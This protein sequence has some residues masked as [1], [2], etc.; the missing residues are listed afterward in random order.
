[1]LGRDAV[2]SLLSKVLSLSEADQTEAV[3]LGRQSNLT[4]YANSV[5]HQNVAEAETT[6]RVRAV[7]GR[8]VGV[9]VTNDLREDSLRQVTEKAAT[10]A[11]LQA[12]NPDFRS[13]P[14]PD[15]AGYM[16]VDA[17]VESTAA[18]TPEERARTV[19]VVCRQAMD[20][21][22]SAAG[23]FSTGRQEI[24]VANSLGVFGYHRATS[25]ELIAL[26]MSDSGSGY[27]DRCGRDAGGIDAEAVA[28]EA[29]D[30]ALSSRNPVAVTPG[31]YE[32]VLQEYAVEDLV[33]SISQ[34][35]FSA[36]AVQEGRSFMRLGQKVVGDNVSVWDDALSP[37]GFPMP[38]DFEGVPKGRLH[39]I[40]NGLAKAVAYDSYTAGKEGRAST[41][42]ALPAPNAMGPLPVH[43]FLGTGES[44][45]EEMVRGVKRGLWV[46][47]FHYT[48]PV[49]PLKVIVTGMTRDGTFLIENGEIAR[50]VKNLRY[51][52]SYLDALSNITA[53]GRTA[54][55]QS[56]Y[57]GA[58]SVPALRVGRFTFTGATE[59]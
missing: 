4:R 34:L 47:R 41:G 46:T 22:L 23:A 50:P 26:V 10:F 29:I 39:L 2:A 6:I 19:G 57:F 21:G 24:A 31:D 11:R 12:D 18:F 17:Y 8:K 33:A 37:D 35:G 40:E 7:V 44:T 16:A 56:G 5:I 52:Q 58:V 49:H 20:R 27:A 42:H 9:A 28:M 55:L 13:L 45:L 38:F 53:I 15:P 54:K 1:M 3:F 32:V 30:K 14:S 51:T 43:L 48:R 36:Q 25:A 59:F